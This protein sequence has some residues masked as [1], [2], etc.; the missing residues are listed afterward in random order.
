[1]RHTTT[2]KV[3][4]YELDPYN[5]VNH[6]TYFSYFETARIDALE[7][8]GLAMGTMSAA[9]FHIVVVD[10][11]AR[12]VSPA[13]GGDTVRIESEVVERRRASSVWHQEMFRDNTLLATLDILGAITDLD[14][15]PTR[16]PPELAERLARI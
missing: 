5:H 7:S 9:G 6:T 2:I 16:L 15:K 8:V 12:F 4:F 13:V 14:G 10:A 3:R 11:H 1:M